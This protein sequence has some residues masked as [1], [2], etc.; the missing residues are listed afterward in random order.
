MEEGGIEKQRI[1]IQSRG[2][3]RGGNVLAGEQ[4]CRRSPCAAPS[5]WENS[6]EEEETG[7]ATESSRGGGGLSC[8]GSSGFEAGAMEEEFYQRD[9]AAEYEALD[10]G[11]P[12]SGD[13][14][15]ST[16]SWAGP[17]SFRW[18]GTYRV[19]GIGV[20]VCIY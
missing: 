14:V 20:A 5:Y 10:Y 19:I 4:A 8:G 3:A 16:P 9:V 18:P 2:R 17:H 6:P 12:S 13:S 15:D 1:S 11:V 7:A